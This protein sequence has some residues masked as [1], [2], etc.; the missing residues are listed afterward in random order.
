MLAGAAG[1][2]WGGAETQQLVWAREDKA[3]AALQVRA[4]AQ[5]TE[6]VQVLETCDRQLVKTNVRM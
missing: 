5:A 1:A 6:D 4:G 3:R 2:V